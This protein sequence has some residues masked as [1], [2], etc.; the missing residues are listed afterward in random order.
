MAPDEIVVRLIRSNTL[1]I[2]HDGR[3]VATYRFDRRDYIYTD[4]KANKDAYAQDYV[5]KAIEVALTALGYV[6]D[7]GRMYMDSDLTVLKFRLER[8]SAHEGMDD[9]T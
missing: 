9:G 3:E 8:A 1:V 5:V 4:G 6:P 2:E 7:L